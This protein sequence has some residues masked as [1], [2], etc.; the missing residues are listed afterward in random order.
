MILVMPASTCGLV[1]EW[2]SEETILISFY[3]DDATEAQWQDYYAAL[4][5]LGSEPSVRCLV[6]SATAP[7]RSALEGIVRAVRGK[8]WLVSIVSESAAVRFA[9]STFALVVRTVR[10]FTPDEMSSACEHLGC[11][12]AEQAKVR[13]ALKRLRG[14]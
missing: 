3:D 11:T 14:T 2:L 5:R 10:F 6:Y 1:W 13:Q 7:P 9:A 4:A 12:P 8:T